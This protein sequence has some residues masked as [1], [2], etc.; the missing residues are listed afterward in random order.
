MID[1]ERDVKIVNG[2]GGAGM[3]LAFGLAEE[4]VAELLWLRTL[5][6]T[7]L[8]ERARHDQRARDFHHFVR[9]QRNTR[10]CR[11]GQ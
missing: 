4:I 1:P 9:L 6:Q 2:L 3:T 8:H 5:D 7:F 11:P 10:V